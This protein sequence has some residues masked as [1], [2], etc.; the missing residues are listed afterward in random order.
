MV[1]NLVFLF[2]SSHN[3]HPVPRFDVKVNFDSAVAVEGEVCT[4]VTGK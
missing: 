2:S 3:R 4:N 1:A